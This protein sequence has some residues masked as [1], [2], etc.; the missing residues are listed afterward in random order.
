MTLRRFVVRQ[1]VIWALLFMGAILGVTVGAQYD[2]AKLTRSLLFLPNRAAWVLTGDVPNAYQFCAS[3][4]P[5][6]T[7]RGCV[8]ASELRAKAELE[9]KGKAKVEP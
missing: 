9:R 8:T 4:D 5:D 6:G 3:Q 7:M 2:P 1:F